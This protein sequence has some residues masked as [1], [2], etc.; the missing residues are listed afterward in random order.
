MQRY[1]A[2]DKQ[3][4]YFVL[5]PTDYHHI[6]NVMRMNIGDK[7][8]VVYQNEL[9]L[10][11]ITD[12]YQVA[13]LDKIKTDVDN[14]IETVLCIPLLSEQ[15][16]SFVLQK[17]TELGVNRI[18]PIM[19][20]RSIVK[21]DNIK[22]D[23]KKVR[24]HTICKEASEQSKRLDIPIIDDIQTI[25]SLDLEGLKLICSTRNMDNTLKKVLQT[26]KLKRI[27]FLVGPEGGFS[28]KEEEQAIAKGF[29]PV[30][31][32]KNILRVETVP[33]MLL[34]ILNYESWS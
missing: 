5:T 2:I 33:I 10:S 1:F 27:I 18:I 13:L 26:N 32:G 17:A 21:R 3:D 31:L 22:E 9:Y 14:N 29:I 25:S 7:V 19:T 34:S 16:F 6:K 15:K 11:C 23:K 28:Q 12:D 8:E 24:W 30:S 20:E 4:N